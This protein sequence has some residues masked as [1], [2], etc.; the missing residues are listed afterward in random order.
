MS[1]LI[2]TRLISA[3]GI[4]IVL[5]MLIFLIIYMVPGSAAVTMLEEA[6]TQEN[7]ARLEEEMGLNDPLPQQYLRWASGVLKG[8]F[9]MSFL[10]GRPV[11]EIL[12]D[13]LPVTLQLLFGAL[14]ISIVLG[15]TNGIVAALKPGS[16][17][18]R[19]TV[20]FSTLGIAIP[21]FWLAVLLAAFFGVKLG[22]LPVFG[23][24]PFREDPLQWLKFI[25]L[26]WMSLGIVSAALVARQMR[27]AMI[28]ALNS[29]FVRSAR[30]TG[31][32]EFQLVVRHGIKNAMIPVITV[33]GFQV[34]VIIGQTLIVELV[35]A[36]P[37]IGSIMIQ[38]V[39]DQ[40]LPVVQG[41]LMVLATFVIISNL[42][43]DISYGWLNPKVRIT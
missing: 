30:G 10:K 35:F 14:V 22:I 34:P 32:P 41:V 25:I 23:F 21:N 15:L 33:I 37:G 3:V 8:D 28:E 18:D 16:L 38:S 40:D 39:L 29:D 24:V 36:T 42:I 31:I 20:M 13:K 12:L 6:A 11:A 1:K 17:L 7:I 19:F 4:F 9:G 27:S 26:P 43:V 5:S 2:I